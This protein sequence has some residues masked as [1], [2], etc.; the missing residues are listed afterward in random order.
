MLMI[1]FWQYIY[2]HSL[3]NHFNFIGIWNFSL[4]VLKC[5]NSLEKENYKFLP[6]G[7]FFFPPEVKWDSEVSDSYGANSSCPLPVDCLLFSWWYL[8][9]NK[10]LIAMHLLISFFHNEWKNVSYTKL[11]FTECQF[12]YPLP[13]LQSEAPRRL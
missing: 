3:K 4:N 2:E 12:F 9:M 8:L 5:W 10:F 13:H 11:F 7:F 1:Q 6:K